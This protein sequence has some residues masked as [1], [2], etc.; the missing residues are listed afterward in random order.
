MKL[1]NS[2]S[3]FFQRLLLTRLTFQLE[4]DKDK[5]MGQERMRWAKYFSVPMTEKFPAGF[6]P[7]TLPVQ[8]ALCA[9]SQKYPSKLADTIEALYRSFWVDNNPNIGDV[10]GFRPVLESVLGR[11]G[12]GEVLSA[13]CFD[14]LYLC[15]M[16][17]FDLDHLLLVAGDRVLIVH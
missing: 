14:Q 1:A 6:P 7:K 17:G 9:I 13:V 15:W 4:T 11:D 3:T 2:T 8:R 10:E 5:W 12:A 16:G